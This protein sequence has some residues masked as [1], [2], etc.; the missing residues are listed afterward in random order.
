VPRRRLWRLLQARRLRRL[1][2]SGFERRAGWR[3]EQ[4]PE[5]GLGLSR[6]SLLSGGGGGAVPRV[7]PR[8][9]PRRAVPVNP[10]RTRGRVAYHAWPVAR[11]LHLACAR[12]PF[13][14]WWWRAGPGGDAARN[15]QHGTRSTE[16]A[17]RNTREPPPPKTS[18]LPE[19]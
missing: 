3:L 16:H 10:F 17:A 9:V 14:F 1:L 6:F 4:G 15:T 12:V 8:S 13:L 7:H 19:E 18:D 11:L 2:L 5:V